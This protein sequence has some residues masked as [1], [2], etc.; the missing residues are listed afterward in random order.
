MMALGFYFDM[1]RC[2]GCRACQVACKDKNN[3]EVG[4]I[5]RNAKTYETGSFPDVNAFSFSTSCNHCENPACVTVCPIGAM[6]KAEDGTVICD[7]E[8][9]DGCQ[10]C[11]EICPYQVPQFIEATG[12]VN[13]C[14]ACAYLRAKGEN[15]ACVDACPNRALDFGDVAELESKYGKD[16]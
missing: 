4:A 13:K 3:L 10:A 15:P 8:L 16:L 9:C 6:Y 5:F 14:D 12:K 11:V 2:I 1:T 7:Q